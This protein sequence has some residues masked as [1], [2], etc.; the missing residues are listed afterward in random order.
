MQW[1]DHKAKTQ[2]VISLPTWQH[3]TLSYDGLDGIENEIK[4]EN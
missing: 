2:Y 4:F 1:V 3:T